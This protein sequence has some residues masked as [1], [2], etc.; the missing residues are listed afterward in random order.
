M[1]CSIPSMRRSKRI[2]FRCHIQATKGSSRARSSTAAN[3][4]AVQESVGAETTAW[5][6]VRQDEDHVDDCVGAVGNGPTTSALDEPANVAA[7]LRGASSAARS[8]LERC[9]P[10]VRSGPGYSAQ[11][12]TR[13]AGA[14]QSLDRI[15]SA[16]SQTVDS[17][18]RTAARSDGCSE[19]FSNWRNISLSNSVG[20]TLSGRA[21]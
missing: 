10:A 3:G 11:E 1:D 8:A 4:A 17:I 21:S 18:A 20:S 5:W 13:S 16:R 19:A 9:G 12:R 2:R 7:R 15:H 6:C 14:V